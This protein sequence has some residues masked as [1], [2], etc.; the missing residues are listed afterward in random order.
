MNNF[1]IAIK[2]F[3]QNK[4]TVTIIGVFLGVAILYFGYNYR[5]QKAIRPVRMPY[6]IETIQPRT[7]ITE[8]MVGFIDVPPIR[9]RGNV[10]KT[11]AEI[12]NRYSNVNTVIPAGSL[13]YRETIVNRNELPDAALLDIPKNLVP[14]N[15]RVSMESTYGNSIFPGNKIDIYFKGIGDSGEILVGKLIENVKILAVKD[16]QGRHVFEDSEIERTPS[17]LIFAVPEDIHL[18][19]RSAE[20]MNARQVE[21]IPVPH[22]GVYQ[23]E[24][25]EVEITN[26]TIQ[27]FIRTYAP[28]IS[29]I[30]L[31]IDEDINNIEE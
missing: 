25:G 1:A 24:D 12:I 19:L 3:F 6:A 10:I 26:S 17:I 14:Y 11:A 31:D 2:R 9:L 27:T 15:F 5:V 4:N 16:K 8:D 28:D 21:L 18:L 30:K 22:G 13:F 20:Y 29:E 7:K 23:I